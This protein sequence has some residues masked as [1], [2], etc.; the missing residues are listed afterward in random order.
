MLAGDDGPSAAAAS[1]PLAAA[2]VRA[3]ADAFAAAYETEDGRGLRR[4]LTA[5]VERVLPAGAP[6]RGRD[7]VARAYESQFRENATESYD[8]E[9]VVVSG[10]RS[11]R[12][13]A[14]YRVRRAGGPSIAGRI[15]LGVVRDR[16]AS[17][18]ALIAVRPSD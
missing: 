14:D 10:G 7:A 17:R 11:G 15:V 1:R 6:L 13:S 5:D 12:A 9:N 3:V 4:L 18:I 2:E 8:L 16:G